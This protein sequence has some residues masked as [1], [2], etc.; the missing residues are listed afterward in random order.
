MNVR[1]SIVGLALVLASTA[2]ADEVAA[3]ESSRARLHVTAYADGM[4]LVQETR[5]VLLPAGSSSVVVEGLPSRLPPAS[6][7]VTAHDAAV[8]GVRYD[9]QRLTAAT[10]L[11]SHLGKEVTVIRTNPQSGEETTQKATLLAIE[12]GPVLRIGDRIE[13]GV[14]GRI[15]Y[16]DVPAGL[17]PR[18]ALFVEVDAP[19]GG[20]RDL[21]I[22]YMAPGLNWAADYVLFLDA[23]G[24][25][26]RLTGRAI[27]TNRS[28]ADF[29]E[30]T[31]SLVAGEINRE[32]PSVPVP[33]A[34]RAEAM[35][36]APAAAPKRQEIGD[37]YLYTLPKP[38]SLADQEIRQVP[39]LEAA[40][41]PVTIEYVSTDSVSP[42]RTGDERTRTNPDVRISFVNA[43]GGV[44]GVPLPA[45]VA[46]VYTADDTGVARLLGEDSLQAT[47]V[48]E[49]ATIEPGK[50]FD[51]TV[52]RR[53]TAFSLIDPQGNVF[54]A[55]YEVAVRNA[56]GRPVVVRVVEDIPGDWQML[57]ESAKH[58]QVSAGRVAWPLT[59]PA[60]G[61]AELTYRVRVRQ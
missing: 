23:A 29:P 25:R 17:R 50:A 7:I 48:G 42:F 61:G 31:L 52:S 51:I 36:A 46:R 49:R 18:P 55:G 3:P 28:G 15:A 22:G 60:G 47:P 13:A 57:Q 58:Q 38:V 12:G 32:T 53:Q 11:E 37:V 27:V 41:V 2:L 56:R 43:A 30:A 6:I 4:A 5:S 33:G 24:E 20:K 19:A 14:P 9:L 59:V 39:L 35:M 45:G 40:A 10:L 8:S 44:P 54:E 26:A 16:A 1:L 21:D 34:A